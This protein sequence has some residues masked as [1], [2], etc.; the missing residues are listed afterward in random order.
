MC[1]VDTNA[2]Q[3][4]RALNAV[5]S[6]L[7]HG[8]DAEEVEQAVCA[9]RAINPTHAL[10]PA[11]EAKVRHLKTEIGVLSDMHEAPAAL[12]H[13]AIEGSISLQS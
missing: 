1:Q 12:P 5:C 4:L 11:L 2:T 7:S 13:S 9:M 8:T 6:Q 3:Y 10:L